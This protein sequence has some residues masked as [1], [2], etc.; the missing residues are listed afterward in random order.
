MINRS[1]FVQGLK[2]VVQTDDNIEKFVQGYLVKNFYSPENL[3]M[4]L[5]ELLDRKSFSNRSEAMLAFINFRPESHEFDV[6]LM[7]LFLSFASRISVSRAD[8]KQVL[9]AAE[10]NRP[11]WYAQ[12]L[13]LKMK[14]FS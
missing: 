10:R 8:V 7:N 4:M 9:Q 13:G 5:A 11:H 2:T 12:Y 6:P 14:A 3:E 1:E